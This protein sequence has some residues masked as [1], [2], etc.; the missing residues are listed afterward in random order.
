MSFRNFVSTFIDKGVPSSS[1]APGD[2]HTTLPPI[3]ILSERNKRGA[4]G[5]MK[6][7]LFKPSL[8]NIARERH[9]LFEK[10]VTFYVSYIIKSIIQKYCYS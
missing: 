2:E 9:R 8:F 3:G 5:V 7:S 1:A 6:S 4:G 10:P